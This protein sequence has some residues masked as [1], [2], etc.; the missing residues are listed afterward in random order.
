MFQ[1]RRIS[2]DCKSVF[3]D[4]NFKIEMFIFFVTFMF[5]PFREFM[6][7]N[8]VKFYYIYLVYMLFYKIV[9]KLYFYL[10]VFIVIFLN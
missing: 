10:M 9:I 7:S 4:V 8:G 1:R 6:C 3:V 2:V 5:F